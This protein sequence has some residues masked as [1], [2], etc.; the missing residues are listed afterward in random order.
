[1]PPAP[2]LLDTLARWNPWGSGR[3]APGLPRQL[4][5]RILP[6]LDTPEVVTLIGPRRGGKTTVLFQ[7][8]AALLRAGVER[9]A[10]FHLNL[11]EPALAPELGLA[12]LD[13]LYDLYRAEVFPQGKAYLFLD[14]VQRLPGWERWVRA[15]GET[16]EVK[17]VVTGSSAALMSRE[18]AT[19]LTGRHVTFRVPP[20]DFREFVAFRG[21]ELPGEP[22]LAGDPPILQNALAEFLRWG[23]FPEV[24]LARDERRKEALLKQYFEDVLFKDVAIR[25]EVR[26]LATLRG[27]AVH[28]L[29]QTAS[30]VSL[31]RLAGIFGVSLDL[32]RA[33][34]SHLEEAFLVVFLPFYTLKTAERLRRPRKVHAGDTGLRNAVSLSGSPDRGRLAETAVANA[35]AVEERDGVYY[36]QGRGEVDLLVRRGNAA[37]LLVQ[38]VYE[39]LEDAE[40]RRRELAALAEAQER[41]PKAE[42]LLLVGRATEVEPGA[43]LPMVR[44]LPLWRFLLGER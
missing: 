13:R 31:Q 27:V 33:Y 8:M 22:R 24:V 23:G 37:R 38:V 11:E 18:L 5:A 4:T 16:E 28:L 41:F 2:T 30:L 21:V 34:C 3:L 42:A 6:F 17:I 1:M 25:H 39:G 15:R 7:L 12:L 36:W 26:D 44:V 35:L 20:L 19:L 40:V 10:L 29:G 14:E 32:A 9:R 43:L